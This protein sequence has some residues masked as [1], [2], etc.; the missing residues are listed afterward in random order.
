VTHFRRRCAALVAIAATALFHLGCG[1]G[2]GLP[3]EGVP[4]EIKAFSGDDQTGPAGG[5]L[6]QPVVVQVTDR[7]GRPV[8]SQSVAFAPTSGSGSVT[9]ASVTTDNQGKAS[10]AWTL[11]PA[12]GPQ[13]LTARAEGGDAPEGL[14][15]ALTAHAVS[16]AATEIEIASGN[17]Q[18]G[19]VNS[20]LPDPLVARVIDAVGNPVAGIEVHWSASGG[21]SISP[22]VVVTGADGLAAA[23]RVLG[24][25]SGAES[26][27]ATAAGLQGSPLTFNH[28]AVP[29]T[30]DRLLKESGD[31]QSA[32]AGFQLAD[33]LVVRLVDENGNGIGG[34]SVTWVV[35]SGEGS[36]DPVN[37]TTTPQGYAVTRWTMPPVVGTYSIDAVFSGLDPVAFTGTATADLPTTIELL[38]GDGQSATAGS[39]LPEP[40]R[41][42]V[43]DEND[44]GVENVTVVW[45][46]EGDGLVNGGPTAN[47]P[48]DADGIA[49]VTR[50]LGAA[51][52]LYVTT[53]EVQGLAGS[54]VSFTSNAAIGASAKLAFLA[55]P[56][57]VVV[58]EEFSP[59]VQVEI[60]D[61]G[62]NR[63]ITASNLVTL[64]SSRSGT[65]SGDASQNAVAG[66]ATFPGLAIT[67]ANT[68]YTLRAGASG[69][70]SATS[71][72]FDVAKGS[73]TM[74]ITAD[75][76]DPSVTGQ[77]VTINFDV[78]IVAPGSGSLTKKVTV[79]SGAQSCQD[80]VDPDTGEGSCQIPFSGSGAKS[81][82][83][84]YEG[85]ANFSSSSNSVP[86]SH[87]VNPATTSTQ[88]T[89]DLSQAS[90]A[91]EPVNVAFTVTAQSPGGGTPTGTV[92]L[93]VS[94]GPETC[95]ASVATGSCDLTFTVTGSNRTVTAV[96]A[97]SADYLASND[98]E[99]HTVN[100]GNAPPTANDDSYSLNEDGTLNV[101]GPAGVL[102]NDT[103]AQALTA[104][105]VTDV[106]NGTLVLNAN[107]SFTY[108]PDPDFNGTDQFVYQANDGSLT[109]QATV[110]LTVNA[111]NDPPSFTKG[112]DQTTS[113]SLSSITGETVGGWA[114]GIS[115]GPSNESSQMVGFEV[116]TDDD[117]A[118]Q[119]L[120]AIDATSGTLTYK[121][122]LRF[123]TIE[124]NVTVTA[125]DNGGVAAG[126]DDASDSQSLKITIQP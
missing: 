10:T 107:G 92:T 18:T 27:Q 63:V 103:D 20:A 44:N 116:S 5:T 52:G 50:V 13:S 124:V 41:V 4:T 99:Q 23:E 90:T 69:L 73:T 3:D 24:G 14:D 66:V 104:A 32:P 72:V 126:G 113:S 101:S 98:T 19:A 61:A 33:S 65:L 36:V 110:T 59:V 97:G 85:D 28:T 106:A 100:A 114:T 25:S 39:P 77:A 123:D 11:G 83:A 117:D 8:A 67:R 80:I 38:S 62:G 91:G 7:S 16:G 74:T 42:K 31:L 48:T 30:P 84:S 6:A 122:K 2:V 81:I 108:T 54:P 87:Q 95:S 53:A 89:T 9:P 88:I 82:T 70:T 55:Q 76:P 51:P 120:P 43:T 45:T 46:A 96:Y 79:T 115:A 21:G 78:D 75:N 58:G 49:E 35:G 22:E 56:G 71:A 118:F 60:L 105:L 17:E 12:A 64:S 29:A 15:V 94:G 119:E 111:V 37:A 86:T 102:S 57:P 93:T 34:R 109:D 125:R 68:G 40:L 1:D 26:A 112:A 121:P 47:V